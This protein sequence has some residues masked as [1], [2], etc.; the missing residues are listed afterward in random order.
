MAYFASATLS[1]SL[2][3]CEKWLYKFKIILIRLESLEGIHVDD[4][5]KRYVQDVFTIRIDNDFIT[6][7]TT[8][9]NQKNWKKKRIEL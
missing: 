9:K 5:E 1:R 2:V 8:K 6:N 4:N 7:A 3:L